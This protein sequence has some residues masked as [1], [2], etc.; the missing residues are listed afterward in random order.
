MAA[1]VLLFHAEASPFQSAA[2]WLLVKQGK[3][4]CLSQAQAPEVA[5]AVSDVCPRGFVHVLIL[6]VRSL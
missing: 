6:P 2:T 1:C 5:W 4:A 3:T